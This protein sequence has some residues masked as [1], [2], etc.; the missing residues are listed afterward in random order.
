M[1]AEERIAKLEEHL[2]L[3][4]ELVSRFERETRQRLALHE[5]Q[6]DGHAAELAEFRATVGRVLELLERLVAGQ[7]GGNRQAKGT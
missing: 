2:L 3:Q 7:S 4:A 1:T 6:L 5:D